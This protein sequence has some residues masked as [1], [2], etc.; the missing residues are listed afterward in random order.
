VTRQI[1]TINNDINSSNNQYQLESRTKSRIHAAKQENLIMAS[2]TS[3]PLLLATAVAHSVLAL[4]HTVCL[5]SLF[6]TQLTPYSFPFH[7]VPFQFPYISDA[8]QRLIKS[9]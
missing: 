3:H 6:L 5:S 2:S 4:G 8:T 1:V 9:R 7:S